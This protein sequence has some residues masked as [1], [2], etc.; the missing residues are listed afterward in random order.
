MEL[1]NEKIGDI[2]ACGTGTSNAMAKW[3]PR[4]DSAHQIGPNTLWVW[5][6]IVVGGCR[7]LELKNSKIRNIL[8]CGTRTSHAMAKRTPRLDSAHRIGV[9]T[10]LVRFIIVVGGCQKLELKIAKIGDVLACGSR[11]SNA[12]L[13]QRDATRSRSRFS[14]IIT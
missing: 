7:K 13:G 10:P 6:L 1:K 8:A 3:T 4:L 5:I 9:N 11:T 14:H 12:I 2:L